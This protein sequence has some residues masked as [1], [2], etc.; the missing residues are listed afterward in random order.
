MNRLPSIGARLSTARS[1]VCRS[2]F[3]QATPTAAS[4]A[5]RRAMSSLLRT[6]NR[7]PFVA[8]V[9]HVGRTFSSSSSSRM[10]IDEQSNASTLIKTLSTSPFPAEVINIIS[11]PVNPDEVEIKPDGLIYMPAVTHRRILNQAFGPGAW[12]LVALGDATVKSMPTSQGTA[13]ADNRRIMMREFALFAHGRF[14]SQAIGEQVFYTGSN[15]TE[16][17]AV[18]A[19]RS[20]SLVRC[21]KDLGIGSDM[22]EPTFQREWKE[23][24]AQEVWVEHQR[25]ADKRKFWRR[26][27]APAFS[28]PWKEQQGFQ[29]TPAAA[30]NTAAYRD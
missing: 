11:A 28:F 22:W 7:A 13:A 8:P 19:A 9:V 2:L 17:S 27:T 25:T 5:S 1:P 24:Y 29:Q 12:C 3:S 15:M 4:T 16:G 14:V 6:T 18:E 23:K 26:K 21:C 20:N 30:E 10:E